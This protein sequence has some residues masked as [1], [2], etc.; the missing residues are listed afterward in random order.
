MEKTLLLILDIFCLHS[1]AADTMRL[2][3]GSLPFLATLLWSAFFYFKSQAVSRSWRWA[4]SL[5]CLLLG[6]WSLLSTEALS[7]LHMLS[8][9]PAL[10]TW[11]ILTFIPG[12]LLL[13]QRSGIDLSIEGTR[14]R[15]KISLLPLW[16]I[17]ILAGTSLVIFLMAITS[18]P[19]NFDVQ[20]YHMPRQIYWM[21]QG[22]VEPFAAS[23]THQISM[24]VLGEFLGL[25]LLILS[26]GDS[27]HNLIQA[28]F[29]VAGCG[30][31]TLLTKSLGGSPRAQIL[32]LL[33]VVLIPVL[34]FEASNAKNDIILSFFVLVPLLIGLKIWSA[35]WRV[36][37]ATLLLAA[38]G[39]GLALAT[40]GTA[41]VYLIPPALL[42]VTAC[43]RRHYVRPLL[44][45]I[46]PG[47]LLAILPATPQLIRN[48]RV[49]HSLEGPN[50]HH[51]NLRHD[52]ASIASVALR[53]TVGQFTTRS[54]A[55]NHFLEIKTRAALNLIGRSADD[56]NTTFEGQEFHLPYFPGLE[57]IAPAPVQTAF[58]L[59]LPFA[60]FFPVFRKTCGIPPLF[61]VTALSL[62]LFCCI[63]RWQ[64]WQ[65]RL[66]IPAY[67]MAAPMAGFLLDLLHP[68][69]MPMA[70]VFLE[71]LTLKPHLM[72]AGQR[73]LIG[74]TSIFRTSKEDQMSRM[75]PGRAQEI[76][77]IADYLKEHGTSR[78]LVD[79]GTTEIYALL[80]GL[81]K[82][83]PLASILSGQS[84]KPTKADAFIVPALSSAGIPPP[85][86]D[87]H[88]SAPV[89]YTVAWIGDY[90]RIFTPPKPKATSETVS[91]HFAGFDAGEFLSE[92]LF[93]GGSLHQWGRSLNSQKSQLQVSITAPSELQLVLHGNP[94]TRVV[95]S[96]DNGIL[97]DE[98]LK[99]D[100]LRVTRALLPALHA[101]ETLT[102][103]SSNA[104]IWL[105]KLT[106]IPD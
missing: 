73:P 86:A 11:G 62:L 7:A 47:I 88:P 50:L 59:L 6:G 27:W 30:L 66:L 39:A 98:T 45:A 100:E 65:G 64:P 71:L 58:L 76:Q 68:S 61:A 51:S 9:L 10:G 4:F 17:L 44:L 70:F 102:F 25:N 106:V 101:Q 91:A 23:H 92:P 74:G 103:E 52:P 3:S 99:K 85:P 15:V 38:L 63:F 43:I 69:W 19:M 31:V 26:G 97:L 104:S 84:T 78:I 1:D 77:E 29:L 46:L 37:I 20:I 83:L 5:G 56:P 14:L 34:F 16:A 81:H 75:M 57:D 80:R 40:K 105:E 36:S 54:E 41:F 55:W 24:P 33:F 48:L 53:D 93:F 94:G 87:L 12:I 21:M 18:P 96:L 95:L 89:G 32:S 49:F 67:F 79:G 90:Y 72:F 60:F 22:S 82:D 35:E 2:L 28:F 8:L 13:R 42:I